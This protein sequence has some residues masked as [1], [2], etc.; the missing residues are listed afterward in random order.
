MHPDP[1]GYQLIQAMYYQLPYLAEETGKMRAKGA[2]MLAKNEASPEDR[3]LLTAIVARVNDRLMQTTAAFNKAAD[4]NPDIQTKLGGSL[5]EMTDLVT[6]AIQVATYSIIKAEN[7]T[8]SSVDYVALTTQAIDMQ[9]ATNRAASK[10]LESH[11]AARVSS[12]RLIKWSMM[13]SMLGLILLAGLIA[14]VIARSVSVPLSNA[15]A[16]AQRVAKGNLTSD[17]NIVGNSE[18]AQL[19][20]ALKEMNDSLLIIVGNVRNSIDSIGSA[21]NDIAQGNADLSSR[22]ESQASSLEETASSMEEI[23]STVKQS[24]DNAR[25]A[26]TLVLSA[27]DVAVKGGQVVSQ[28]VHTMGAIN[29]S[30]RKIVDI[31]GVID[32]IAFQTNILALNAAVEAARAGEQGRGFA[33][34]AAEVRNLAQRS[35]GAAKEIKALI[36]DSVEKVNAGNKLAGDAG[37]AMGEIV[38]SVRRITDIMSEIVQASQEQSAGIEQVNQAI[39]QMD[40]VTQQNAALVEQA[41]AASESLKQQAVALSQ[42]VA[43]FTLKENTQNVSQTSAASKAQKKIQNR[44]APELVRPK[45]DAMTRSMR[46]LSSAPKLDKDDWEEF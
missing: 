34:V 26:N 18:A 23:T 5:K 4:V 35:A 44:A 3:Q 45:L 16:V 37:K 19:M 11:L 31:I 46:Q 32:G 22:T 2:G 43:I 15:V 10:E 28:V 24:T 7:L 9:F 6:N 17:F 36:G 30:S 41:A 8:Y 33:V 13:G 21:S 29:D 27:A 1:A 14:R 42:S 38:T 39:T 25:Q 20:R 12:L 40:N